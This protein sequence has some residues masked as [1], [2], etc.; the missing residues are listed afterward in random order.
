[1][2][3]IN[4]ELAQ[5]LFPHVERTPHDWLTKYPPRSLPDSAFVTRYAPSPTGFVHIGS[6]YASLVASRVAHQGGGVFFLRIE[7]TDKK[8]EQDGSIEAIVRNMIN[9]GLSPDEGIIQIEPEERE[10]GAYAP[11]TQSER[12]AMYESFAKF[13]VERGLAYP[14][15]D[16]ETELDSL[17]KQ[18]EA[19]RVRPGYYGVWARWRDAKIER[20]QEK[21]AQ[22]E[23]PVIRVRAPFPNEA[24]VKLHDM[25]KGDLDLPANDND[26]VILK[27]NRLPTYH[28]AHVVDDTLM[29]VNLVTRGDEW[30]PSLPLH[31]QLFEAIEQPK[32]KFAHIAPIA[33]MEGTTKRKLSKRKDPE[34]DMTYYYVA[35]YPEQA[36]TEYLLNLANSRFEDWRRE[37]PTT[38]NSEFDFKL[39]DMGKSS[40]LF[41]IV[42]LNDISKNVVASYTAEQVYM[43]SLVWAKQNN[44]SLAALL[45]HDRDYSVRVFNVERMSAAPRK[46]IVNWSD[47]ERACGFFFDELFSASI[48]ANGYPFPNLGAALM[49]QIIEAARHFDPATLKETW[50]IDMRALAEQF[51]FARDNK[52][53]KKEPTAFKGQFGDMMMVIRVAL[54]GKTNTPDL[55]EILQTFGVERA[56]RRLDQA[57]AAVRSGENAR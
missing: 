47:I 8:R 26:A 27:S 39:D 32:P 50:V 10:V 49:E 29:R 46:D 33:K 38:P 34:A 57:I 53:Y 1:M 23:R 55:Y 9:F 35:G 31:V 12:V 54:T 20:I 30:L 44:P 16:S 42:K 37:H 6:I 36:V 28:F 41:D 17:R 40:P 11:Y 24:R 19:Q 4:H 25:I 48:A 14:A 45:E 51:G 7:D 13:L 18:Q 56:N 22:G 3:A 2:T 43:T 21:L 15:F 52:A 5:L